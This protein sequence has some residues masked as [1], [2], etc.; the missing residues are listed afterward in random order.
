MQGSNW[1]EQHTTLLPNKELFLFHGK[2]KT[3]KPFK[4]RN[5]LLP[6]LTEGDDE[7]LRKHS[8]CR[9]ES[10][11]TSVEQNKKTILVW[12]IRMQP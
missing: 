1:C 9:L 7:F 12:L 6:T 11:K 8:T 3:K 2:K 5:L 4:D 10:A